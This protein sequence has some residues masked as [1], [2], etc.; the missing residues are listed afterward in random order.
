[1]KVTYKL[2]DKDSIAFATSTSS[3]ALVIRG[4]LLVTINTVTV[5]SQGLA[6]SE[7]NISKKAIDAYLQ[8]MQMTNLR[9]GGRHANM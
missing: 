7:G 5:E 3:S 6:F 1:M 8:F 9:S 2:K 4:V